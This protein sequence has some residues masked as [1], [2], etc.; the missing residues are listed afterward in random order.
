VSNVAAAEIESTTEFVESYPQRISYNGRQVSLDPLVLSETEIQRYDRPRADTV[1]PRE[2]AFHLLGNVIGRTIIDLGCGDGVNS[3]IL[4]SLGARVFSIDI[5]KHSLDVTAQRA[6][7]NRVDNRVTLL[8]SDATAIPL[9]ASSVDAV[10]CTALLH[11]VDP[12][13]TARQIRRVTG[14]SAVHKMQQGS[15]SAG[16]RVTDIEYDLSRGVFEKFTPLQVLQEGTCALPQG[17]SGPPFAKD[18]AN[19]SFRNFFHDP[20]DEPVDVRRIAAR[21]DDNAKWRLHIGVF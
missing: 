4:A 12:I 13:Q 19:L 7:S 15:S 16:N 8:H 6:A 18:S 14:R 10:L 21:K 5:S 3:V 9:E 17:L 20:G 1:I 11:Q 2:Y